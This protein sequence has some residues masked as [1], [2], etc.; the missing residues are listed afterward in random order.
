MKAF[1]YAIDMPSLA[2]FSA[3]S[4]SF[5]S[6]KLSSLFQKKRPWAVAHGLDPVNAQITFQGN[7]QFFG[8][9]PPRLPRCAPGPSLLL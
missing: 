9:W 1:N 4:L 7:G 3:L 2:A 5:F 8:M 6:L